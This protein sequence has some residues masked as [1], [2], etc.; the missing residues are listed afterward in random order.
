MVTFLAF[1]LTPLGRIAG[2][3]LGVILAVMVFASNQR[4]IGAAK[5]VAQMERAADANAN[6]AERARQSVDAL[7]ADKLRDRYRRD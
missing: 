3:V 5:A 4:N 2:A 7:P 6:K 1:F